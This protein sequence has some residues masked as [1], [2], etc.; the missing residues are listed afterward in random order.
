MAILVIGTWFINGSSQRK[1][2]MKSKLNMSA[3]N[4]L[5]FDM[6]YDE[7]YIFYQEK[8]CLSALCET[9][10][11]SRIHFDMASEVL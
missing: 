10:W 9:R 5:E 6:L 8:R 11:T 3:E 1:N 7:E 2:I 4:L